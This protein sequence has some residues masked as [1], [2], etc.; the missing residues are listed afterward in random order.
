MLPAAPVT[1]KAG[2]IAAAIRQC[3]A[4]GRVPLQVV[5]HQRACSSRGRCAHHR[6]QQFISAEVRA[7]HDY[8][9]RAGPEAT[10]ARSH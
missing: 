8:Q 6:L 5:V 3:A 4:S 1:C 7:R 9:N 10:I 2:Q